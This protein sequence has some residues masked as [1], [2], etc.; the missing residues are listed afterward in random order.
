MTMPAS[1]APVFDHY[2]YVWRF[3][4]RPGCEAQFEKTYG[5]NGEW[6][7]LFG[8]APGY[9]RTELLRDKTA[10]GRYLT[11]DYWESELSHRQFRQQFDSEFRQLDQLCE[12]MTDSEVLVGHFAVVGP[13][14][15]D[16]PEGI[17]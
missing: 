16:E 13:R 11:I 10:P 17:P 2:V 15:P 6:V 4:V 5:P 14:N 7:G 9:L 12:H 1:P 3:Q 8:R